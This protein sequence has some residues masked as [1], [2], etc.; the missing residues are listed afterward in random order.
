MNGHLLDTC[1]ALIATVR[2]ASLSLESRE[3]IER[4]PNFL[5]V[6]SYWEVMLKS[7]KGTLKVGAPRAW[8]LDTLDQ[9]AA[10]PVPLRAEH[11]NSIYH[12][13]PIHQ[14]PFDRAL[15]AQAMVD[16]LTL[17][18]IDSVIPQYSSE[19]FRVIV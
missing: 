9:L 8:W 10:T 19:R 17:I 6:V 7:M 13:R 4:G 11:I 5:S 3:A 18:T 14:D 2:S 16:D 15:I 1:V 12:L